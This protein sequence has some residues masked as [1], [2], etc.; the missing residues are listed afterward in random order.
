MASAIP[1]LSSRSSSAGIVGQLSVVAC[2]RQPA[3]IAKNLKLWADRGRVK[4]STAA[5]YPGGSK[6]KLHYEGT[7][8]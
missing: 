3:A 5:K 4:A 2:S 8:R 6:C 7:M 1:P